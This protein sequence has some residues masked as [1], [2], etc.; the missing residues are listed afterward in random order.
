MSSAAIITEYSDD[1]ASRGFIPI[2]LDTLLP[3]AMFDFDLY[4]REIRGGRPTLYR[5][6]QYPL[7]QSDIDRLVRQGVR[8]LHMLYDERNLYADYLK[9]LLVGRHEFTAVQKYKIL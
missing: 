3:S 8:M 6:R 7:A 5:R 2:A 9:T 1:A 4:L